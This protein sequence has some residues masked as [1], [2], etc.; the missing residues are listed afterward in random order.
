M[1]EERW[2][3][4]PRGSWKISEETV[5]TDPDTG[6][7]EAH[8]VLDRR[9]G[10]RPIPPPTMLFPDAVCEVAFEDHG[11]NLCAPRQIAALLKRDLDEI[12]DELRAVELRLHGTDTLDQG[13]TSRV[14]LE[15]CRERG[16]GAA[17]VH[18]EAVIE[19]LPGK[20][21]LAWTVHEAH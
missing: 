9:I 1:S 19:T 7:A 16:Y 12:C 14:I 3:L 20:P 21:V 10:A 5:G 18:N 13:C 17:V 2:L 8:V 4:D 11:D 15:Y 6:E